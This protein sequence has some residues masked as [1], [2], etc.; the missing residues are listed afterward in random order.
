MVQRS[1]EHIWTGLWRSRFGAAD[2]RLRFE[3]GGETLDGTHQPIPRLLRAMHRA[4]T[5]ADALFDDRCIAVVSSHFEA[6]EGT[7]KSSKKTGF[8]ALRSLGFHA[9]AECEW[10]AP[11]YLDDDAYLSELRCYD[12]SGQKLYRDTLIWNAIAAEMPIRPS[13]LVESFLID[14]SRP[15]LLH[16]YDDRGMDVIA[17]DPRNL[18]DL[19]DR[20]DDWLL[21]Y[22][23]DR[24]NA[25]F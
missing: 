15:M 8:G 3:L 17:D 4:S 25:M 7:R 10:H 20:F 22:D 19:H 5:I 12:I 13:A 24:M 6:P 21:D 11:L 2:F 23:R 9:V 18:R 16:V 14:R 1:T